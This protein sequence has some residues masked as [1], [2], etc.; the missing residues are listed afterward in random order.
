MDLCRY[1]STTTRYG[2]NPF[3]ACGLDSGALVK[4]R[5]TEI[6]THT[7]GELQFPLVK[8]PE[9]GDHKFNKRM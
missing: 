2:T 5:V 1:M 7:I 3:T 8:T 6:E 9:L 4:G